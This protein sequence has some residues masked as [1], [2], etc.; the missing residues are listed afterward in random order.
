VGL[1]PLSVASKALSLPRGQ[2]RRSLDRGYDGAWFPPPLTIDLES[3]H[4]IAKLVPGGSDQRR[5]Q[6][7]RGLG[8]KVVRADGAKRLH[9]G[10]GPHV[11]VRAGQREQPQ[12]LYLTVS[13]PRL[14]RSAMRAPTPSTP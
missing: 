3:L 14:A 7:E 6:A 4:R 5:F 1:E 11:A 8:D 12:N 10:A 13:Q 9:E 2:D